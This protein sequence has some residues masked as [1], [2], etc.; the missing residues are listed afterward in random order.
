MRSQHGSCTQRQQSTVLLTVLVQARRRERQTCSRLVIVLCD[1]AM[2]TPFAPGRRERRVR[3][4]STNSPALEAAVQV[5]GDLGD[6]CLAHCGRRPELQPAPAQAD[7]EPS[8][9]R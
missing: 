3:V 9:G 4:E 8:S 2:G 6:G 5:A 1:G 7:Q